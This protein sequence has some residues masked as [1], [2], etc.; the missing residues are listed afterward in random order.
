MD[1]SLYQ[2]LPYII[3]YA[4]D[5]GVG[6]SNLL[7]HVRIPWRV[8]PGDFFAFYWGVSQD[9]LYSTAALQ[10]ILISVKVLTGPVFML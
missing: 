5:Q 4:T 10:E 8:S 6:S 9:R 2:K 3:R 1:T 7:T